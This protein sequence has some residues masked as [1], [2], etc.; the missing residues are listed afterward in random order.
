M[1]TM[2]LAPEAAAP[3]TITLVHA[4]T[5]EKR[6]ATVVKVGAAHIIVQVEGESDASRFNRK[7]GL[8][9]GGK[10]V[11]GTG[12]AD[13]QIDPTTLAAITGD[14]PAEAPA[15][16]PEKKAAAPRVRKPAKKTAE[17]PAEVETP[18]PEQVEAPAAEVTEVPTAEVPATETPVVEAPAAEVPATVETPAPEQVEAPAPV[19]PA[20]VAPALVLTAE[21]RATA[22][23]VGTANGSN[24]LRNGR[25]SAFDPDSF[26]AVA[27]IK[28]ASDDPRVRALMSTVAADTANR[29]LRKDT[30]ARE[31]PLPA[32]GTHQG[33]QEAQQGATADEPAETPAPT[34][35]APE[36]PAPAPEDRALVEL[37][38]SIDRA[39]AHLGNVADHDTKMCLAALLD[40]VKTLAS[41]SLVTPRV[42]ARTAPKAPATPRTPHTPRT[43][44]G[45]LD[46]ELRH[47][48]GMQWARPLARALMSEGGHPLTAFVEGDDTAMRTLLTTKLGADHPA[49]NAAITWAASIARGYIT[50]V[51]SGQ[52]AV[53][54]KVKVLKSG[55]ESA[56]R[57]KAEK[58]EVGS[59]VCIRTEHLDEYQDLFTAEA[60]DHTLRVTAITGKFASCEFITG[61]EGDVPRIPLAALA[62]AH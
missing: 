38:D 18:A 8:R 34:P 20:P 45:E 23:R 50:K 22:E 39:R 32:E 17:T 12:Y 36:T 44:T 46:A 35:A 43:S 33:A 14:A 29:M 37:T 57:A 4:T 49:L 25:T 42:S 41:R 9:I 27:S 61:G 52:H 3:Q 60:G 1:M 47:R 11:P 7:N 40:A 28:K 2:N 13:L 5:D 55:V 24:A 26:E 30:P 54:D 51:S 10:H 19:T 56:P 58:V 31:T 6:P 48:I 53:S 62:L 15:A 21:Q 16:K 59:V